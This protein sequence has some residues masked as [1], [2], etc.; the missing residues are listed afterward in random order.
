MLA[1]GPGSAMDLRLRGPKGQSTLRGVDA[2][3]QLRG[4]LDERPRPGVSAA[5]LQLLA[6]F[7]PRPLE[8][9][10]DLAAPLSSLGLRSGDT[11]IAREVEPAGATGVLVRRVVDSNNSCL[12]EAT[13]YVIHRSRG[14]AKDSTARPRRGADRGRWRALLRG[15]L[16][17]EAERGVRGVAAEG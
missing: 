2:S 17:R 13:G 5:C 3:V 16:P 8:L 14:H 1:P 9:P 4:F 11:L 7:P 12:F 15:R 6:G 10:G